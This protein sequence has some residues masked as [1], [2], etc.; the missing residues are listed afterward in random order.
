MSPRQRNDRD[1]NRRD[2]LV[3]RLH[4][5]RVVLGITQQE[6]ATA[7]GIDRNTLGTI[8]SGKRGPSLHTMKGYAKGMGYVLKLVPAEEADARECPW[9]SLPFRKPK[10]GAHVMT[11]HHDQ[12]PAEPLTV[13][14]RPE[15]V[16]GP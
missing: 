10:M 2:P 3:V 5:E 4:G 14:D 16:T 11:A 1:L 8:E 6:V 15:R 12:L 9:C 7:G 13:G